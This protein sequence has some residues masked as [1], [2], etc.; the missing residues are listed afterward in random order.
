MFPVFDSQFISGAQNISD[1]LLFFNLCNIP[2]PSFS[3]F[4][5]FFLHCYI[6]DILWLVLMP[7]KMGV[8]HCAVDEIAFDIINI[9]IFMGN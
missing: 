3:L 8:L 7:A 6:M 1:W 4:F 5:I 2:S 9:F